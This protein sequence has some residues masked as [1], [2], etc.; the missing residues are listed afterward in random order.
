MDDSTDARPR[1]GR[2]AYDPPAIRFGRGS[3][4][5]LAEELREQ[6]LGRALVVCGSTV[7]ETEAVIGP[8]RE[9]LGDRLAGVFAETT[10]EKR[11]STAAAAAEAVSEVGADVLVGL[12]G[13]SSLDV[14]KLASVLAADA[15]PFETVADELEERGTITVPD[16][17][18]LPI[19]SVPTTLAGADLSQGA[20]ITVETDDGSAT[21]GVSDPRLMPAAAVYD[22]EL[23]ATTP[24]RVLAGSAMNGFDKGI[25]TLYAPDRTPITDATAMRGLSRFREGLEG[26]GEAENPP[27]EAVAA[28]LEGALLVQYGISRPGGSTLSVVHA[29]GHALRDHGNV[30]QGVAH[31]VVVPHVLAYLF[32]HTHARRDLLAEALGVPR[33]GRSEE[34]IAEEVVDRVASVRDALGLPSRLR[35]L[36]GVSRETF[37]GIARATLEDR[38]MANAPP[39]L[40]PTAG[41]VEEVLERAW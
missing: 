14:A 5:D 29:F 16:R 8:V 23:V 2:F 13:G 24:R 6:D 21:G 26:I 12:G 36:E 30:Q 7:G 27:I 31:A 28:A 39:G 38:F 3:A 41:G 9:G 22:P 18:L 34:A 25:E 32:E 11:L 10:P 4:D 20:G 17:D 1:A 33:E 37:P 35:D 40:E 15:R 19:V